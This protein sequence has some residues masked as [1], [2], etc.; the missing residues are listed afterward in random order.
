M[1]GS[2]SDTA[3]AV[4]DGEPTWESSIWCFGSELELVLWISDTSDLVWWNLPEM[5]GLAP[6]LMAPIRSVESRVHMPHKMSQIPRRKRL[7]FGFGLISPLI[8]QIY[9]KIWLGTH[10]TE[11]NWWGCSMCPVLAHKSY[12]K[13]DLEPSWTRWSL[14][15]DICTS[16]AFRCNF[17]SFLNWCSTKTEMIQR[18]TGCLFPHPRFRTVTST[19]VELFPFQSRIWYSCRGWCAAWVGTT[20]SY[21]ILYP[22]LG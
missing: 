10:H 20:F 19:S 6:I 3:L 18:R 21:I 17:R 16:V 13:S 15:V 14:A 12:W 22:N 5:T 1:L 4:S 8:A 7:W 2:P 9:Q 11:L